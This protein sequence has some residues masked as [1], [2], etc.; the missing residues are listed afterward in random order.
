VTSSLYHNNLMTGSTF[1]RNSYCSHL[2]THPHGA[3]C[4]RMCLCRMENGPL[5]HVLS[6]P[7]VVTAIDAIAQ[8]TGAAPADIAQALEDLLQATIDVPTEQCRYPGCIDRTYARSSR[9]KKHRSWL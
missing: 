7:R 4:N 9:C 6:D 1:C 8:A 3:G 2:P 5:K